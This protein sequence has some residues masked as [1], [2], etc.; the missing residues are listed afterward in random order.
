MRFPGLAPCLVWSLQSR[1]QLLLLW[2]SCLLPQGCP[3]GCGRIQPLL[4][5][6]STEGIGKLQLLWGRPTARAPAH[7]L[8]QCL[9]VQPGLDPGRL[10]T[11]PQREGSAAARISSPGRH[12]LEKDKKLTT[13][14]RQTHW[15]AEEVSKLMGDHVNGSYP[16]LCHRHPGKSVR[17]LEPLQKEI[18]RCI[19]S[20]CLLNQSINICGAPMHLA[21]LKKLRKY[22]CLKQQ[23]FLSGGTYTVVGRN[24]Q[25]IINK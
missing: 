10:T 14:I 19:L 13:F 4:P 24:R 21:L 16:F 20:I 11:S 9:P 8:H 23:T 15:Q 2:A 1:K 22:Q 7:T 17:I 18:L 12:K 3:R 25:Q 6:V 5:D